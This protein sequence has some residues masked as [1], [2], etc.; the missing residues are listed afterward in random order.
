VCVYYDTQFNVGI[1][2]VRNDRKMCATCHVL[3]F[4]TLVNLL[5]NKTLTGFLFECMKICITL[6]VFIW[7]RRDQFDIHLH[8]SPASFSP[9]VYV[10]RV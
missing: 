7:I 10:R 8:N 9:R 3:Y 4:T 5:K 2:I 6:T 1:L